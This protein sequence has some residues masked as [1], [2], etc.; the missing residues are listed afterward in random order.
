MFSFLSLAVVQRSCVTNLKKTSWTSLSLSL[1]SLSW[2]IPYGVPFPST[3]TH[4]TPLSCNFALSVLHFPLSLPSSLGITE[5]HRTPG[6]LLS[7]S[8]VW[9]SSYSWCPPLISEHRFKQGFSSSYQISTFCRL[10]SFLSLRRKCRVVSI[11][12]LSEEGI[13]QPASSSGQR[14][15]RTTGILLPLEKASYSGHS[16]T[17]L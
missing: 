4:V 6:S 13:E 1:L 10:S 16:L 2:K 8:P 11:H 17:L 7:T 15:H 12:F 5:E 3:E 9:S 14:K